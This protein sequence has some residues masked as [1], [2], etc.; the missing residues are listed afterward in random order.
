M[1]S[2]EKISAAVSQFGFSASADSPAAE[3]VNVRNKKGVICA[4]VHGLEV[5]Q[6]YSGARNLCGA[7]VRDAIKNAL[8]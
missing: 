4:T 3:R 5:E 1:S 6:K 2:L 8:H 7:L